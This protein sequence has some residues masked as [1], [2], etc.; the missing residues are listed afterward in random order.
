MV[1]KGRESRRSARYVA[2]YRLARVGTF[3]P[4]DKSLASQRLRELKPGSSHQSRLAQGS[5]TLGI[6]TALARN[7]AD[8]RVPL[9]IGYQAMLQ[10]RGAQMPETPRRASLFTYTPNHNFRYSPVYYA[11]GPV[12]FYFLFTLDI[13]KYDRGLI[14]KISLQTRL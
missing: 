3:S 2:R 14:R 11:F 7:A 10:Q 4:A 9:K 8:A 5:G 13:T 6:D 1:L 12:S